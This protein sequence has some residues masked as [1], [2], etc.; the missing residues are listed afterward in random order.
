MIRRFWAI[1]KARNIEFF[2]DKSSLSWNLLFPLLILVGFSFIFDGGGRPEYKVGLVLLSP[3]SSAPSTS[4]YQLRH[5]EF[6]HYTDLD[7]AQLKLQQHGLDLLI[8]PATQRYWVNQDSPKGYFIEK[9]MLVS[10]GEYQRLPLDG[11]AIRYLDWVVPGILGMNMMFSSLFGVGYVIVRYRKNAVL[12]RLSATPVSAFEFLSAQIMSRLFI[13]ICISSFIFV[14]CNYMFNFY[15][16]GSYFT[17]LVIALLGAASMIALGLLLAS[18]SA[19]EE[20]TGGLLNLVSWP[21]M[22]FSG[23]WFSLEGAPELLK[24]MA[25]FLPLTHLVDAARAV[26]TKG[27]GIE[28]LSY[29]I[30]ALLGMTI[31]YLLAGAWL[32]KWKGETR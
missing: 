25:Q 23:V 15:M 31:V 29:N 24:N 26:M 13:V 27:A 16:L 10:H 4:F 1:F 30:S 17:L 32:F 18:R 21:M 14:S 5:V 12:K 28:D 9:L 8:E 7:E 2:R 19:S 6:V 11:R 3:S 20:L 22:I